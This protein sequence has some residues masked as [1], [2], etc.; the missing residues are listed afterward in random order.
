M[1][2]KYYKDT[3]PLAMGRKQKGSTANKKQEK[4]KTGV[5]NKSQSSA[6]SKMTKEDRINQKSYGTTSP[7]T[8][9]KRSTSSTQRQNNTDYNNNLKQNRIQTAAEQRQ[10]SAS[11]R[12][13]AAETNNNLKQDIARQRREDVASTAD[14]MMARR[15]EAQ[16]QKTAGRPSDT[17]RQMMEERKERS[18]TFLNEKQRQ[19]EESKKVNKKLPATAREMVKMSE[20]DKIDARDQKSGKVT[21][22]LKQKQKENKAKLQ[23]TAAGRIVG[24]AADRWVN[25]EKNIL[26]ET[27]VALADIGD[28][29]NTGKD[30]KTGRLAQDMEGLLPDREKLRGQYKQSYKDL[31]A[32]RDALEAERGELT[33]G[34]KGFEKTFYSAEESGQGM[35]SDF[36]LGTALGGRWEIPL[37]LRTYGGQRGKA[38]AEGA[39][40][41]EDRLNA[42]KDSIIEVVTE[43]IGGFMGAGRLTPGKKFARKF[44]DRIAGNLAKR[45][46]GRAGREALSG[47][48]R[49]L[50]NTL[51]ENVEEWIANPLEN[52]GENLIYRNR[53]QGQREADNDAYFEELAGSI[54]DY[55]AENPENVELYVA[56]LNSEENREDLKKEY[57]DA[58]MTEEQAEKVTD[59]MIDF[60][61]AAARNDVDEMKKIKDS[62][63]DILVGNVKKKVWDWNETLETTASTTL[64]MLAT[65]IPGGVSTVRQGMAIK[66]SANSSERMMNALRK[67]TA[68]DGENAVKSQALLDSMQEGYEPTAT[69]AYDIMVNESK[70]V[71]ESQKRQEASDSVKIKGMEREDLRVP[72]SVYNEDGTYSIVGEVTAQKYEQDYNDTME[73][74]RAFNDSTYEGKM[75]LADEEL[76]ATVVASFKAGTFTV[77]ECADLTLDNPEARYVFQEMTGVDLNQFNVYKKNGDVDTVKSNINMQKKLLAM[78]AENYIQSARAE[79]E[80]WNDSARGQVA[81][82]I[83]DD[84]SKISKAGSKAVSV[85]LDTVDPR[86]PA[87]LALMSRAARE[88]YRYAW[89]TQDSWEDVNDR[90]GKLFKSTDL[91]A[92]EDVYVAAKE[93]RAEQETKY[94]N[95]KVV[96]GEPLGKTESGNKKGKVRG[97]FINETP[98]NPEDGTGRDFKNS[99]LIAIE[100][101]AS[102]LNMDIIQIDANDER[103]THIDSNGKKGQANAKV[104]FSEGVIYISNAASAEKIL[105]EVVHLGARLAAPQYLDMAHYIMD[106][107]YKQDPEGT[108]ELLDKYHDIYDGKGLNDVQIE[109]EVV[110]DLVSKYMKDPV[111][112]RALANENPTV[113]QRI[114]NA[115]EDL[116]RAIRNILTSGHIKSA[117]VRASF[118]DAIGVYEDARRMMLG[119]YEEAKKNA[120]DLA[121]DEWQD[122]VND[123]GPKFRLS[124]DTSIKEQIREYQ[125]ELADKEPVADINV[126]V[127]GLTPTQKRNNIL[128]EYKKFGNHVDVQDYGR[129]ELG[130]NEI[131]N[132]LGYLRTDAEYAAFFAVP[133]VLKRGKLIP[134]HEDHKGRGYSTVSF[135]APV[136]L[137]GTRGNVGVVVKETGKNHYKTHRILS[138]DGTVFEFADNEKEVR[139]HGVTPDNRSQRPLIT[140]PE[141]TIPSSEEEGKWS[142]SDDS[143]FVYGNTARWTDKRIGYLIR[144]YGA[145]HDDSYSKAYAVM[146]NPRDFLKLTLPDDYLEKWKSELGDLPE[147]VKSM[148]YG[149]MYEYVRNKIKESG[150]Y[151]NPNMIHPLDIEELASEPQTPFLQIRAAEGSEVDGA[152]RIQ[153]HEGR[154]RMRALLE[155]GIESVPVVIEDTTTKYSKEPIMADLPLASQSFYGGAVNAVND[156]ARV[157][158]NGLIP[159]KE[160][161]RDELTEKFGGEADVKFSLDE[162]VE[163][164]RDLIA[165]HNLKPNDIIN[166]FKLGGFPMPSIAVVKDSMGHDMYGD[167][168]LMFHSDTIDPRAYRTNEVYGGDAWTPT[169]PTIKKLYSTKKAK[170]IANTLK[171][172]LGIENEY[173][174]LPKGIRFPDFDQDNLSNKLDYSTPGEAYSHGSGSEAMKLAYLKSA[175]NFDVAIPMKEGTIKGLDRETLEFL[176]D[177]LPEVTYA[178]IFDTVQRTMEYEPAV[179]E[180]R[181]AY[182]ESKGGKILKALSNR[183]DEEIGYSDVHSRLEALIKYR[184]EGIPEVIDD[185]EFQKILDQNIDEEE[186]KAWVDDL[187]E[188]IVEKE[189]IR[190]N[191]DMYTNNGRRS[192]SQLH[193]PVTLDNV[194]RAMRREISAGGSGIFGANPVGAAQKKYSNLDEVIADEDRLQQ[195]PEKEYEEIKDAATQEFT[196]VCG[197]IVE[198][199]QAHFN[200]RFGAVLDTGEY[201]AEILN[202]TRDKNRIQEKLKD[203]YMLNVSDDL[204]DDL[205][206]AIDRIANIPTGYFEAKPRRA[207]GIDEVRAAIIPSDPSLLDGL[208]DDIR[209]GFEEYGVPIYEYDHNK[210]GDRTEKVNQAATEQ[211]IRFSI[212]DSEGDELSDGQVAFFANSKNRD[213]EDRL[214]VM[215]HGTNAEFTEFDPA[216][217]QNGTLGRAFYFTDS[218]SHAGQYGNAGRYYLNLEHPLAGETHEITKD[219][220]R[221]FVAELAGNEDYGI[222]NYGSEATIDSVTDSVWGGT[223]FVMLRDLN[224]SCV[225]DFAEAL[226]V[227]NRVNGTDYDGIITSIETVAFYPEQI[228]RTD[229]LNPTLS[230]DTRYSITDADE[231]VLSDGQILYFR[232]SKARDKLGRLVPVYHT[233]NF[234]GFTVF[235]P[236][237]SDDHRSLFFCA[238]FD[239]S[240]TY[241]ENANQPIIPGKEQTASDDISFIDFVNAY[242][243]DGMYAFLKDN[244]VSIINVDGNRLEM[245]NVDQVATFVDAWQSLAREGKDP[246]MYIDINGERI[247]SHEDLASWVKRE[248]ENR[249]GLPQRGYYKVYLNLENPLVI[250]CMGAMWHSIMEPGYEALLISKD[251][252]L[253]DVFYIDEDYSDPW[254][255]DDIREMY[256]DG[257]ADQIEYYDF[258]Y[259]TD[260]RVS[261]SADFYTYQGNPHDPQ[262]KGYP[263]EGNTRHWA[264]Y[265]VREGYDGVIFLDVRDNGPYGHVTGTTDV[266]IAFSSNQVKDV[267]NLNPTEN[268]DIRWSIVDDDESKSRLAYQDAMDDSYETL[269]RYEELIDEVDPEAYHIKPFKEEDVAKFYDALIPENG[270]VFTDPVLEEDRVRMAKSKGDFY[271]HLNAK[272]QDRWTTG[273]EVLDI[274]SVKTDIRNLVIGVMNN[275]DTPAKYRNEIVKKT[276]MDVRTAYQLMKQDQTG[277]A[278]ALLYHSALRMIDNVEFY[279]D[280]TFEM[281]KDLRDYLRTTKISLSEEYWSDVDYDAFRKRN[282]GRLKLVKGMTNVDQ[283]YQELQ[284][285]YPEWF[286]EEEDMT[287]PDQ[288]LQI[289][290]VLDAVQPYK[291]AYSSEA[292]AELAFDIAD[293]LYD[294]M[295]GGKEVRSLADTYKQRYDKKTKAMKQR[296]AE[297][298]LR[299]R[300]A[301][302]LGIQAERAKWQARDERR[303][304]KQAH[305]KYFDSIKNT[306]DKLTERLLTNTKE[307]HIPEQY[308]KDLAGLLAAFDFQ[309]VRSKDIESKRGYKAQKTIRLEAMRTALERIEKKSQLFHVNDA[310]TEIM[311]DLL[312]LGDTGTQESIEGKALDE[313]SY[314]ELKKIDKLLKALLHEFNTYETVNAGAKRQQAADIGHTQNN[315]SLEHASVMGPGKDYQTAGLQ[316]MDRIINLDMMTPAYLFKMI[317]PEN[318]GLGLMWREIRRSFDRYVRNTDQLNEWMNEIVG[319]YHDKGILWNKYGSGEL[320]KWRSSNYVRT[321]SLTNGSLS[322]TPA[323]MMSLYCLSKRT[324]A[325]GHMV[326]AGVVAAPVAFQAKIM[327]DVKQ[328]VNKALP[329]MLTD[330]DIK[331]IIAGLT[332]E[333]IKVADQIQ[334]LMATKMADWGNEASMNVLGIRLFE[335]PDYFPIRSDKA[336]LTKDLDPSQF[337]QA[338]R[339]FGFTKAVQ[340]GARNAIMIEDIFDVVVEHCNNMN[341]Y[342]SY[343]EAMND[344]MKVYNYR[345]VREEGEYTVEQALRHAYSDKAP[346][347]IMQFMRD[348]NGNVSGRPSGIESLYNALLANAKKASVFAN[349]RVA[350]QQP[351]AISRAF[352]VID[353]KYMK[354]IKI[355]RGAMTEMFEHCP[356]ALWK[357]WGYYDINMGK[358]IEDVIMNNGRWLEEKATDLYGALD[359]VTWTAIWQMVKAEMKDTHPE[360]KVGTDE[361]WDACNERMSEIVDLTQVVDSPMHRSHAMRDKR[362]FKKM[363][364]AFMAEPTLTFNMVRDGVTMTKEACKRGKLKL[365]SKIL[366]KTIG[367]Y[368]LQCTMV[369]GAQSLVD[370]LR[371]K[372]PGGDDD[373]DDSYAHLVWINFLENWR[374]EFNPLGKIYVIKD[375][376]SIMDGWDNRNLALQGVYYL[377]LGYRQLT[378]DPYARSSKSWYEN[379][380][381]GVGYLSGVPIK[382]MM[383]GISNAMR[384]A[385]IESPAL[386]AYGEFLDSWASKPD[387]SEV[388]ES[389]TAGKLFKLLDGDASLLRKKSPANLSEEQQ[390]EMGKNEDEAGEKTDTRTS[391]QIVDELSEKAAKKAAGLTGAERDEALWDVLSEGY[392]KKLEAGDMDYIEYL[393]LAFMNNGGDLEYFHEKLKA[394]LPAAYKKTIK[395]DMTYDDICDQWRMYMKMKSLGITDE[396]VSEICYKSNKA[397]DLKAAMRLNNKQFIEEESKALIQAGLSTEDYEKLYK[398]RNNGAKTYKG[399]YKDLMKSTGKFIW[400]T[401]GE[402]TSKFGLR[403]APTAGASTNHPAIDIGAP[404][405]ADVV[406]ADGGTVIYVGFNSGYGNSVG[407]KHDNGMVTYYNHL[408]SYNVNEGDTVSQ[409]QLIAQVGS[410]GIS[411]GPHLDFK[412][413]D[414]DGNPVDPE[415]YL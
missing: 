93:D 295:A 167:I 246:K 303:K 351:T 166:T 98:Y 243:K 356:I 325:Y 69:Q 91:N 86:D 398:Y 10:N 255:L 232:N 300:Q 57:M 112:M 282:F 297:A 308:K 355:T 4:E 15:K 177:K 32:K 154:H 133:R 9:T 294:I 219:Q 80:N 378:G 306:Y 37:A 95:E 199:N 260:D 22:S 123:S 50:A 100:E 234:G 277:I 247:K 405:G 114:K 322:L 1:A 385:G 337:E 148:S 165:V 135:V 214:K 259:G 88:V 291:E 141:E 392:T 269:V 396:E 68:F 78:S 399:K 245:N 415:K 409:G 30:H 3:S 115:I 143:M 102:G 152:Y 157:I 258:E 335:D 181:K 111:F 227:F 47:I 204:M 65:G 129:V 410:T 189:G 347:F 201:I 375:M 121:I 184:T 309:T 59:K 45:V 92:L 73:F 28:M 401:Q 174:D 371:G 272:W 394:A 379:M 402:I 238:S 217:A 105:H 314:M 299:M 220:L 226:K 328:K 171:D 113:V 213:A 200:N 176:D 390:K 336:G 237:F 228:K 340:P 248:I 48:G 395:D 263:D 212:T 33:K 64:L 321:F 210:E 142:L 110:A 302:Q 215:L 153:G 318:E 62:L 271:N 20:Q 196:D 60:M 197:R 313:L 84:F 364:T 223:D 254:S 388:D 222:E 195:M 97:K 376:K 188:G 27:G 380:L 58:G 270:I 311:N 24:N 233:T 124:E 198:Q 120:A 276:L 285:R 94:L 293:E 310:V 359:N 139:T 145:T 301:K 273:G 164:V 216:K 312:G 159:I 211:D 262:I 180:A 55:F 5:N 236:S 235:D 413:L 70:V 40:T 339:N 87:K 76:T 381:Y 52:L 370:A 125:D 82:Q 144:E 185:P 193:D 307:K 203:E 38:E 231:D 278:S 369:A 289:E 292:A 7:S 403:D 146:M 89:N 207:V 178:D 366:T 354:G 332:P 225:G 41:T 343:T 373:D 286:D 331:T 224:L 274:K 205:M 53:L 324:Q 75:D 406:A 345:E 46:G 12:R 230:K 13:K 186:Y 51:E 17:A 267:N 389:S 242:Y 16:Y 96:A 81:K 244:D 31:S 179:R 305:N 169:F 400:P 316:S 175:K 150:E 346:I 170:E 411:T 397:K 253:N 137:N 190:N 39:T 284:D 249:G 149:E 280:D 275:S 158:V 116:L 192:W 358:S 71:A 162:P 334:E 163:R 330:A 134:G 382:T 251:F 54:Q 107:A 288:L 26:T 2:K 128:A 304:E 327:S 298:M 320:T 49:I 83:T 202:T 365:A 283:V 360:I 404:Y 261:L 279:V 44:T 317:D 377:S 77:A 191:T 156:D 218:A 350:A 290:H 362:F 326:G 208:Y 122:S 252:E 106:A 250:D 35:L 209:N 367:V 109:E 338:I 319:P 127:K 241:A 333:Q 357:S 221:R 23:E 119:V 25:T 6:S 147:E 130:S 161:N 408:S 194:V 348:L 281:Y 256:G 229:N 136:I 140:S 384:I 63:D 90:L 187:F 172:I 412:I 43:K 155:A 132:S 407:I 103:L 104:D 296:H 372:N 349:A 151:V 315:I 240:Q 8:T 268:P 108:Q 393:E 117:A 99:E 61:E 101:M 67:V 72:V 183:L 383:T 66:E 173:Q 265:A 266:Y 79:Q 168:T 206:A 138:P 287:P 391:A 386:T 19:K 352:Y 126:E 353:P 56:E 42:A 11:E 257:F 34:A 29:G 329:L 85:A 21:D 14:E 118:L 387:K 368:L 239:V 323:Q 182:Y 131:G 374:D 342:N 344:F 18:N 74:V 36:I 264:E 341:L 160:S 363:T 414:A 361:Y